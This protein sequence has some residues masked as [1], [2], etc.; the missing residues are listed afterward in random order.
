MQKVLIISNC[1]TSGLAHSMRMLNQS[2]DVRACPLSKI[3]TI[4]TVL[5]KNKIFDVAFIHPTLIRSF[6]DAHQKIL[7]ASKKTIIAPT[8]YFDG[9]HPDLCYVTSNGNRISSPIGDYHSALCLAAFQFGLSVNDAVSLFNDATYERLGYYGIWPQSRDL[10]IK[11]F[12]DHG[13]DIGQEFLRW[14]KNGPFLYS[15]NHP[16]SQCLFDLSKKF[17]SA[18][19]ISYISPPFPPIDYLSKGP[20]FPIYP[21]IAE[22]C[23]VESSMLFKIKQQDAFLDLKEFLTASF[24][25]YETHKDESLK[26]TF[27]N[28]K[29]FIEIRKFLEG[30]QA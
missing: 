29:R 5:E 26:N 1:A 6:P 4:D 19:N 22:R 27:E 24:A 2:V 7:T 16:R 10:M 17:L 15:V 13:H 3:K 14:T 23:G 21:G 8:P 9:Y 28:K 12:A 30:K 18:A 25:I 11:G 20:W